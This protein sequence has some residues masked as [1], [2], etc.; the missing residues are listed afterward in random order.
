MMA[1]PERRLIEFTRIRMI[2]WSIIKTFK[3]SLIKNLLKTE[4]AYLFI[5]P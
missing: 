3:E 1:T 2:K 4:A 5:D